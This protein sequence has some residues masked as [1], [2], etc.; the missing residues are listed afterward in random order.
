MESSKYNSFV[1]NF[2]KYHDTIDLYKIPYTFMNEFIYY[3]KVTL[4]NNLNEVEVFKII[5]EFYGKKKLNLH[6]IKEEQ[7]NEIREEKNEKKKKEKNIKKSEE[8]SIDEGSD[9]I[10]VYAFNFINFIE[11]YKIHLR[12]LINREQEDDKE[13]FSRIKVGQ[14]KTY[15]RNGYYLSNKLLNI[16]KYI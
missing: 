13:I 5:D 11:Y 14:F 6:H 7:K 8:K 12:G 16:Y 10:N 9:I 15:G 1:I 3:S 4:E 2:C